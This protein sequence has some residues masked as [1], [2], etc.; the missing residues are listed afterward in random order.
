MAPGNTFFSTIRLLVAVITAMCCSHAGAQSKLADSLQKIVGRNLEDTTTVRALNKLCLLTYRKDPDKALQYVNTGMGLAQKLQYARGLSSANLAMGTC[1]SS[2]GNF[3]EALQHFEAGK[4]IAVKNNITINILYA[5][6][7]TGL[8]YFGM[9]DYAK[10][11][12]QF[13]ECLAL[14]EKTN[15]LTWQASVLNNLGMINFTQSK[16]DVAASYY[17]RVIQFFRTTGDKISLASALNNM[18]NV[19]TKAERY[20]EALLHY[21]EAVSIGEALGD[22]LGLSSRY[23]NVGTAYFFQ[24][25]YAPALAAFE[26]SMQVA[27]ETGNQKGIAAALNNTATCNRHLHKLDL[28]LA[29]AG[30]ALKMAQDLGLKEV[31]KDALNNLSLIHEARGDAEKGL[32]YYKQHVSVKDSLSGET[33]AKEIAALQIAYESAEKSKEISELKVKQAVADNVSQRRKTWLIAAVAGIVALVLVTLLLVMRHRSKIK[34]REAVFAQKRA[35]LEQKA[36]RAQMNPHFIF[37]SLNSIQ[38]LYMDGETEKASDYMADFSQLMRKILDSSGRHKITVHEEISTLQLYLEMERLRNDNRID[39]T[40]HIN[41][42]IDTMHTLIPPLVIQPFVE[43]AIWHGILPAKRKGQITISLDKSG[44]DMICIIEDNG[45]G[46]YESK[47]M[48][49]T[50]MSGLRVKHESK[51]MHITE[52]RLGT[53][54]KTEA[55]DPGTRVTLRIPLT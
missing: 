46:I 11:E 41:E 35:E 37:N 2:T 25:D 55:L 23:S 29:Q 30:E 50:G 36:L 3:K 32:A 27:R 38:R 28:A 26:K 44:S 4:Q 14:A 48:Q 21:K 22:K 12:A 16:Y 19:M 8:A 18:G 15:D 43:N 10:A 6:G 31:E 20:D 54:I 49:A 1:K 45:I 17:K 42:A 40:I 51:G 39:Y 13:L 52:Q 33:V 24:K 47:K 5:L 9:G 34:A 7:E 53:T